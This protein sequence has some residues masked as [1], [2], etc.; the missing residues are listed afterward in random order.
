MEKK[1]ILAIV[2]S[3]VA[4]LGWYFIQFTFFPPAQPETAAAPASSASAVT[5]SGTE[6]APAE[7]APA[8]PQTVISET[9]APEPVAPENSAAQM[10]LSEEHITIE[11]NLWRAVLS[12]KGG[13]LVSFELK[14]HD[15][16]GRYVN[17]VLPGDS[18]P[19]MFTVAFGPVGTAPVQDLFV[20]ERPGENTVRFYRDFNVSGGGRVRL[21]KT[22]NFIP[23]EYM[24]ELDISLDGGRTMN[25]LNFNG[26]AY[27][28][29]VGPQ[30]G[31]DFERLDNQR[32]YRHYL[33]F[34]NGK[35]KMQTPG[36]NPYVVD[37]HISWGGIIGKYFAALVIP[38]A[39][40]Y[41][42]TFTQKPEEA[43]IAATNRLFIERPALN[44]AS[45][46]SNKFRVYLGPKDQR[47]L[48]IYDQGTNSFGL[49]GMELEK[50]ANTSGFWAILSPLEWLLKQIMD[51]FA[52]LIPNYGIAIILLTLLVKL[53]LF[54]LTRK[55]SEGTLK[56]QQ[57]APRIKEIQEKYKENQQKMQQE[58]AKIYKEEGYNPMSGCLPLLIQMP[59]FFAMYNM[60]NN[61]FDL[62]G[63]MFIPGWI[64]D[65]SAPDHVLEFGF[66]IPLLGWSE[67]H[68]LPFLY[69]G[70]QLLYSKVTATPDQQGNAQ[71]KIMMYAMPIVF[72]FI[73][74]NMPSG[75]EVYWIASNLLTMVQQILIN[76]FLAKRRAEIAAANAAKSGGVVKKA[77]VL[78]P[79]A[80]SKKKK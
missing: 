15:D 50:A 59:I 41:K 69:V 19:H 45:R 60:F 14:E 26:A 32:D 6:S 28:L 37:T 72:F 68:I 20:V 48:S 7:S 79:K 54:P 55:S 24:F 70:S 74:Y 30:I 21:T 71:M 13:D 44:N 65:L 64:P 12:N 51:F 39:A 47:I 1:T 27:T 33:T 23:G 76:K 9:P 5:A 10:N 25:A 66:R 42:Y 73:L 11:S 75:L 46:D 16:A 18:E 77:N 78:P 52:R 67:L 22:Y 35:S 38:D 53:I 62:R 58:M 2:L 29:G 56:M 3:V 61:Y 36:N 8:A 57:V 43:G 49:S 40:A 17:M 63:A 4:I 34:A 80:K 31:P